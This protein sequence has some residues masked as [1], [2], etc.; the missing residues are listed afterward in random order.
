MLV[1]E[2]DTLENIFASL[3]TGVLALL[4]VVLTNVASDKNI[5]NKLETSQA[6]TN[7]KIEHLTEEVRKH[8]NFAVR[9]PQME[10]RLTELERRLDKLEEKQ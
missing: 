7:T 1:E 3:I 2:D 9:I 5:T 10:A 8:N 6:V 4:G